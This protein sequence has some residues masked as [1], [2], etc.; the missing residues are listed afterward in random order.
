MS[1]P[2][3]TDRD[4]AAALRPDADAAVAGDADERPEGAA[5]VDGDEPEAAGPEA[6]SAGEGPA[7]AERDAARGVADL[8]PSPFF[9]LL[10]GIAGLAGWFSWTRAEVDWTGDDS[11]VYLPF[12][13]ILAGWI[14]SLALHEYGHAALAYRFGDRSLRGSG[15]LRLNPFGFR[16][17][18]AGLLMPVAFLLLGGI[19]LPGPATYLDPSAVPGKARRSLVATAGIT[20]N[21][22]LAAATAAAVVLLVPA[23]MFTDNWMLGGL[24]YLCYLNLGA[25][26]LNVLPIPGLDGFGVIAPHLPGDAAERMRPWGLFGVIAVFAV[27]WV[28]PVNVE[29][30]R[31]M[32]QVFAGLGLPQIDVGFG[33]VL[34]RFWAS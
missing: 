10:L 20:V 23:E 31:V 6:D 11:T 4:E 32:T 27:L 1:A 7:A 26:L 34:L 17:L 29:V 3:P 8:L 2:E 5:P 12:V 19:G 22:V 16:D 18:F 30:P 33:E 9:V 14:I 13:F 24:M 25:A 21:L 15:Y 28:P